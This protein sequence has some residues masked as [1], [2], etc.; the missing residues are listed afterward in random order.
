MS[1]PNL[2]I[3][4]FWSVTLADRWALR[5]DDLIPDTHIY[6]FKDLEGIREPTMSCWPPLYG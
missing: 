1:F 2:S 4:E 6:K 3:I 5:T